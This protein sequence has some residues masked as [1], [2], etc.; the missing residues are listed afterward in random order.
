GMRNG[1]SDFRDERWS[2]GIEPARSIPHSA[3]RI[4]HWLYLPIREQHSTAWM[5]L[6]IALVGH[7]EVG[8]ADAIAAGHEP[9]ERGVEAGLSSECGMDR[10]TFETRGG[11]SGSNLPVRFR[12]PHSAF[13]TGYIS[14]FENNTPRPG[15]GSG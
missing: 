5:G 7:P 9:A 11:H 15:W 3:F 1:S 13:R 4:P 6:G 14:Q 10:A 8:P 2:L 12:T